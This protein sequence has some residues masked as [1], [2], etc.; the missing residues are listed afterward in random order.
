MN[1]SR[2]VVTPCAPMLLTAFA[3]AACARPADEAPLN[4]CAL[5]R[6]ADVAAALGVA[7][8]AGESYDA[9]AVAARGQ[10][11]P[12][13]SS[14]CVWRE[15]SAAAQDAPLVD[16]RYVILHAMEWSSRADARTFL[17]SFRDAAAHG[18]IGQAPVPLALGDEA[19]W[20]GDGVAVV[21]GTRSFGVS[22]R[23]PGE[24]A[25]RR[26][27]EEALAHKVLAAISR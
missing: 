19:L 3:L 11:P 5:L 24:R 27:R 2:S 18:V 25:D 23:R 9:G 12:A 4:A 14:T 21:A 17:T 8:A 10:A 16:T 6:D 20:W 1:A 13:Y 26:A 15:A 22:V 7:V